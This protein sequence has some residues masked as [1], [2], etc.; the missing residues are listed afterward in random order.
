[1]ICGVDNKRMRC[2][3]AS[4][5]RVAMETGSKAAARMNRGSRNALMVVSKKEIVGDERWKEK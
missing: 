1:M 5:E 4:Y 2:P 3:I